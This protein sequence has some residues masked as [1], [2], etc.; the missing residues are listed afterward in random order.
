MHQLTWQDKWRVA[1]GWVLVKLGK[2]SHD[3]FTPDELNDLIAPHFP[4]RFSIRPPI[5][6]GTVRVERG[7]VTLHET[8]N[9]IGLQALASLRISA[10]S[11]TIYRAH[12]ML[13][14]SCRPR[15][16]SDT[17]TLHL[18]D[19]RFDGARLINDDYALIK[20]T[21]FLIDKLLPGGFG[22]LLSKSV[23]GGLSVL[24]G[25]VSTQALD[26]LKLYLNGSMQRILDY[27]RPQIETTLESALTHAELY[28][29]MRDDQ[30]REYLFARL[31]HHVGVEDNRL[32]FY[33]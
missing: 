9:R 24:S 21:R 17:A 25:G 8:D 32:R 30:W 10:L 16:E 13:T 28:H 3:D 18:E 2:I 14:A 20:D 22:S 19:V 5:G 4:Q 1:A 6:E 11:A 12:I 31:G 29:Q 33:F 23:I 7:Q 26:Y 27:H 15:Y